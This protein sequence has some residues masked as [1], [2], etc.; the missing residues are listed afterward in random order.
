MVQAKAKKMIRRLHQRV[1]RRLE[2]PDPFGRPGTCRRDMGRIAPS[3]GYRK[4]KLEYRRLMRKLR[5]GKA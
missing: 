4:R 1:F 3:K 2:P 5:E